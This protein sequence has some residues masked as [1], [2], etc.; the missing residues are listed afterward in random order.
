M[1]INISTIYSLVILST[2]RFSG[3]GIDNSYTSRTSR[4]DETT[5]ADIKRESTD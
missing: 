5:W 2:I 4:V 3:Y 1:N